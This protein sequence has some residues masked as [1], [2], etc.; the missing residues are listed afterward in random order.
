[1]P[2]NRMN[3][4]AATVT[5]EELVQASFCERAPGQ[6]TALESCS[7]KCSDAEQLS[8]TAPTDRPYDLGLW[9]V[10]SESG[11]ASAVEP[12]A[13][14]VRGGIKIGDT[15]AL[16]DL[17]QIKTRPL[18]ASTL[19]IIR[20]DVRLELNLRPL[21][22]LEALKQAPQPHPAPPPSLVTSDQEDTDGKP[23]MPL[24]APCVAP[25]GAEVPWLGRALELTDGQFSVRHRTGQLHNINTPAA[26]AAWQ[27]WR[28]RQVD[29]GY[30]ASDYYDPFGK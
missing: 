19:E 15:C 12:S 20:G 24:S 16:S 7:A 26:D 4:S 6:D 25:S 11:I 28:R 17:L 27:E 3:A 1:M 10:N 18:Q 13:A 14:L 21:A 22:E 5:L 23:P 8:A 29:V 2:I 30:A 9:G